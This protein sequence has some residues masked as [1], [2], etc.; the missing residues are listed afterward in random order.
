MDTQLKTLYI[1]EVER[2]INELVLTFDYIDKPTQSSLTKY[3]KKLET[4]NK[5]FQEQ[6][7][8]TLHHLKI[9][10][11]DMKNVINHKGKIH[12]NMFN[13][14]NNITL[15]NNLLYFHIFESE[16]KNTKKTIVKNLFNQ[17]YLNVQIIDSFQNIDLK[18]VDFT[19]FQESTL[20]LLQQLQTQETPKVKETPKTQEKPSISHSRSSITPTVPLNFNELQQIPG[21]S[22]FLDNPVM[23]DT[24]NIMMESVH[25]G[26]INPM[27]MLTDLLSGKTEE[28]SQI[29]TMMNKITTN[30]QDKIIRGETTEQELT[31]NLTSSVTSVLNNNQI[32]DILM[33]SNLL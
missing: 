9:F 28:N 16:N 32:K 15:F 12:A 4:N 14:M 20:N 30:I 33:N 2:F 29:T 5:F 10:E 21:I 11:N 3:V 27:N 31:E 22:Q 7:T 24:M 25:S 17:V 13:F 6:S 8:I 23:K 19:K 18:N 26:E 1:K